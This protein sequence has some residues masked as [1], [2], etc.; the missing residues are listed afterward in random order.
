[1]AKLR[2]TDAELGLERDRTMIRNKVLERLNDIATYRQQTDLGAEMVTN[3]ARLL[4]GESQRFSVGESSLFLVN[5]REVPL[6]ES[7]LKQIEYEAK[8]RKA[9]FALD[10]DAGTLWRA[11]SVNNIRP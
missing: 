10:H 3:Y 6:I 8:L 2:F 4:S 1:L 5:G 7:R 11:W 9:Y